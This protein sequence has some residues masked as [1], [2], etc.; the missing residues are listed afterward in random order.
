MATILIIDDE[1]SITQAFATFFERAGG[2]TV[3]QANTGQDG[4][5]EV[6]RHHP[7]LVLLDVK[8]PDMTGFDVLEKIRGAG[9]VVI[10]ITGHGDVPMAVQAMQGGAENFLTKPVDLSHLA[11]IVERA[12]DRVRLRRLAR[13]LADRRETSARVLLGGSAAMRDIVEQIDLLSHSD[14][15]TVLILGES[16][17]G[18]ARV[19]ELIHQSSPRASQAFVE[20]SCAALTMCRKKAAMRPMRIIQSRTVRGSAGSPRVRSQSAYWFICAAPR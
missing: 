5:N 20:V 4:I 19:A 8:M 16:G 11:V 1:P 6:M 9:P 3:Y 14:K 18:K 10:M 13:Y 15:T 7:D 12:M 17:T 2:H